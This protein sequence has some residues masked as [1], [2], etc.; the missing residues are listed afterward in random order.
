MTVREYGDDETVCENELQR[1]AGGNPGTH[2]LLLP[3]T[4]R[5]SRVSIDAAPRGHAPALESARVA[6][7]RCPPDTPL[8]AAGRSYEHPVEIRA[9]LAEMTGHG[10]AYRASA[11][12]EAGRWAAFHNPVGIVRAL[13][14]N[15]DALAGSRL[16]RTPVVILAGGLGTRLREAVPDLP[17]ALA[18]IGDKSFLRILIELLASRGAR[19]FVSSCPPC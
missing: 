17:K 3:L 6:F 7:V 19:K 5:T 15:A 14:A 13:T 8:G 2:S 11:S 9:C 4:P 10:A 1:C 16:G 18:P 12:A